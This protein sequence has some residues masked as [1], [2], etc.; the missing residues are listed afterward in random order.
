MK[1]F[2]TQGLV[3][4]LERPVELGELAALIEGPARAAGLA[5]GEIY[6]IAGAGDWTRGEES[7]LLPFGADGGHVAIDVVREPWPDE[8]VEREDAPQL[9]ASAAAGYFGPFAFPFC[10]E[11]ACRQAWIWQEAQQA[12]PRH[13]AFAR[14]RVTYAFQP[15]GAAEQAEP[16]VKNPLKELQA[17]TAVAQALAS[18]P[19]A[20]AYFDPSGE[21]VLPPGRLGEAL[22]WADEQQLPPLDV[23]SNVRFLNLEGVADGWFLMD[24]VGMWQLDIPDHEIFLPGKTYDF[25][26]VEG[27]LRNVSLYLMNHGPVLAEGDTIEGPGGIDWKASL[28]DDSFTMPPRP[29]VR[30]FADDGTEPPEQLSRPATA[31]E[32]PE[33]N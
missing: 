16:K 24:T 11:R 17:A 32:N 30:W 10:F 4:L 21:V 2:F 7:L 27:F 18:H 20:V 5:P 22:T 25:Q 26:E 15:P 8:L 28:R 33:P 31:A 6:R 1:G 3:L 14:L 29:V 9:G 19:A 23:W 12:P 13:Q